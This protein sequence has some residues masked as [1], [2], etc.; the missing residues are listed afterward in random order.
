MALQSQ[1]ANVSQQRMED[2]K[3][4]REQIES[5]RQGEYL[6]RLPLG[7]LGAGEAEARLVASDR[8]LA[9][10]EQQIRQQMRS[11]QDRRKKFIEEL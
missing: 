7:T 4:A 8:G 11:L 3:I 10:Q 1:F 5:L 6:R 9:S 2:Q